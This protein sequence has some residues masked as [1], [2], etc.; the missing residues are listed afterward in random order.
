MRALEETSSSKVTRP[1][2]QISPLGSVHIPV[3]DAY[4]GIT[5]E[6]IMATALPCGIQLGGSKSTVMDSLH[7]MDRSRASES[8]VADAN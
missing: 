6:Q 7:L 1:V 3:S 2:L 5:D 4:E 8:S